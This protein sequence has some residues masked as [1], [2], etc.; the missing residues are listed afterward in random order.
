[1][2]DVVLAV[3]SPS[4]PDNKETVEMEGGVSIKPRDAE[5]LPCAIPS[6]LCDTTR[7]LVKV[8]I[9]T[10]ECFWKKAVRGKFGIKCE[11]IADGSFESSPALFVPAD[12]KKV[13]QGLSAEKLVSVSHELNKAGNNVSWLGLALP[14]VWFVW[15][16]SA[17]KL[18]EG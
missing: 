16:K 3:S 15:V 6:F 9:V 13:R 18:D 10:C 5:I 2:A 12:V 7:E 11:A 17:S 4:K 14:E 8:S 1:M